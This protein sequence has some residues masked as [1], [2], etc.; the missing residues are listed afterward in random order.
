MVTPLRIRQPHF[1]SLP[2]SEKIGGYCLGIARTCTL[3]CVEEMVVA[4]VDT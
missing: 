1:F 4:L 3:G 2:L